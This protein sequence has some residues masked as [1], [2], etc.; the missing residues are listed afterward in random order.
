ME[1]NAEQREAIEHEFGPLLVVAGAGTG[2]TTV[3]IERV[4]RLL[5]KKLAKSNEI[6]ALTFTERTAQEMQERVDVALP[7]GVTQTWI[8]TF[9]SFCETILRAE[10]L[11]IG[12][13]PSFQ[14]LSGAESALFFNDHL[15]QFPLA[16]YRPL[17]NPTKFING[18]LQHF[19]R[20]KDEDIDPTEYL[21]FVNRQKKKNLEPKELE[22][23]LELANG[24]QT[25]ED[26]KTKEGILDISDLIIE[27][28]HLFRERPN[29]L[30]KYQ[31]QFKFLLI[32]EFQDTNFAQNELA[33]LL[34]GEEQNITV[35]FDDD[36]AIYRWRGAA[37]Y[38]V[39]DFKKHFPKAKIIS[40]TKN[41]RSNQEILDLAYN[42]IQNNNPDRLEASEGISKKLKATKNADPK[43]S[44]PINLIWT[45]RVE[46]EAEKVALAIAKLTEKRYQFSEIAILARA[47]NQTEPFMRALKRHGIPYQFLGPAK[48]FFQDEIKDLIAYLQLLDNFEDNIACYRVLNISLL[49]INARD[50]AALINFSKRNNL[51]L[52]EAAERAKEFYKKNQELTLSSQTTTKNGTNYPL[53]LSP[54]S[55]QRL[56]KLVEMI[57]HHF[58]LLSKESPG[59]I[60]YYF[61]K[62]SSLLEFYQEPKNE[63]EQHEIENISK[64]FDKLKAFEVKNPQGRVSDFVKY[65]DFLMAAN[66]SPLASEIDWSQTNAVN[67]IT[68]H[69]AKGLEFPV[70]FIVNLV[71]LR[72]P[73]R[74]RSEQIP[75][76]DEI[77]KETLPV[78]DP[79]LEEERRLFY[80]GVTRAKDLLFLTGASFYGDNKRPKKPSVFLDES[81]G[82]KRDCYLYQNDK[83]TPHPSL[84]DWVDDREE[85]STAT[86]L[87]LTNPPSAIYRPKIN[88]I[89][90]SQISTF[91]I[92]P[93]H[94]KLRYI[95]GL[96]TLQFAA[97][98]FGD[99]IHKTLKEFYQRLLAGE[100]VNEEVLIDIL[101]NNWNHTGFE[102]KTHEEEQKEHGKTILKN[103]FEKEFDPKILPKVLENPFKLKIGP[104]LALGGVI[105]RV[106]E[107]ADGRIEIIDYKTGAVPA[108]KEIDE[109]LQMTIYAWAAS[110]PEILGVPLD[111]QI[112][113]F[114]YLETGQKMQTKRTPASLEKARD[115]ILGK[116]EAIEKSDFKCSGNMICKQC[117]YKLFCQG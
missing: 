55:Y 51:S 59:Q 38:N 67:L 80:V 104:S 15:F 58:S 79:H 48:L 39:L 90:Y 17:G 96:P 87:K 70:V 19:S 66:E 6:L 28:L 106:D 78:G 73:L 68:I 110:L 42:F 27:T 84:F 25:Y 43:T 64:F 75:L 31:K 45:Q 14:I 93:L 117:E 40:L 52:F 35:V 21:K 20:L 16:Y 97:A 89:S 72:F 115:E 113:S 99:S 100:K 107:L 7:M 53:N 24:Y 47:N 44:K 92:C 111:K 56:T 13:S 34:A 88:Y 86:T 82:Q 23:L 12:L 112:L 102:N 101:E 10:G 77:I 18:I 65:L 83:T 4:K 46:E 105:D 103:Y 3:I 91:D 60:L 8:S 62:D 109:S 29:I 63:K 95:V 69:S 9:H 1:L 108:Q 41:Y 5:E 57:H 116:V 61:I 49:N 50:I 26:L 98:S 33:I 81:L 85:Q 76:P 32:D 2:K 37:V 30:K 74:E 71:E 36:Q 11:H 114:Y 54:D 22:R 94:Y